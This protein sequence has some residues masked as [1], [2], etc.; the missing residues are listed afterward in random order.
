MR[1]PPVLGA[2]EIN[3]NISIVVLI[4]FRTPSQVLYQQLTYFLTKRR[5][6]AIGTWVR[7]WEG[8]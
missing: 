4:T 5:W 3:W 2:N 8:E 7:T 1:S 6:I